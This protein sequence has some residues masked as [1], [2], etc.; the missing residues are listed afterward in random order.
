MGPF[1]HRRGRR[2]RRPWSAGGPRRAPE[3]QGW[4]RAILSAADGPVSSDWL[5]WRRKRSRCSSARYSFWRIR[6]Q[7]GL[8][9]DTTFSG[10]T[11]HAR[12]LVTGTL[13]AAG[14]VCALAV[15][16]TAAQQ[17]QAAQHAGEYSQT[18]IQAGSV[19]Y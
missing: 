10:G 15:A 9:A 17:P 4:P 3:E 11:M 13:L 2:R 7:V 14:V 1:D 16:T 8:K 18:D 6:D 12:P 19:V 5:E